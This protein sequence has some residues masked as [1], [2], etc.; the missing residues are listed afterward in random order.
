MVDAANIVMFDCGQPTH[1]FDLNKVSEKLIVRFAKD[2]EE[3][4]TLDNK[5]C[6]LKSSNLVIGN[7]SPTLS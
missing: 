2:D 5:N 1:V 6:K 3:L 7:L 4:T